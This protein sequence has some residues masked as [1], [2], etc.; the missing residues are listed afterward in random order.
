MNT[1]LILAP[2]HPCNQSHVKTGLK[3]ATLWS[4]GMEYPSPPSFMW[5]KSK[6]SFK[7]TQEARKAQKIVPVTA[8][9]L[10]SILLY[11]HCLLFFVLWF[12]AALNVYFQSLLT[13]TSTQTNG[14]NSPH[15]QTRA[16]AMSQVQLLPFKGQWCEWIVDGLY[17]C[18]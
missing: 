3:E 18:C 14:I 5:L 12:R 1:P 6:V 16:N 7:G 9:H 4:E 11:L 13:L 15:L 8:L 2:H 17:T 10:V